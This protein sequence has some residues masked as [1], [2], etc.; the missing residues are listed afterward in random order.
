MFVSEIQTGIYKK[1]NLNRDEQNNKKLKLIHPQNT[2]LVCGAVCF[3]W[4]SL[5][6][7]HK[8]KN[9]SVPLLRKTAKL[10]GA[11]MSKEHIHIHLTH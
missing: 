2:G 6:A 10:H 7:V 3:N 11:F 4:N 1:K 8:N 9:I 5:V